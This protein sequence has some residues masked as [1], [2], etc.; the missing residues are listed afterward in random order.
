MD[1]LSAIGGLASIAQIAGGILLITKNLNDARK[2][3]KAAD[4][5]IKLL[6]AELLS[7]KAAVSQIEDWARYNSEE[8][9]MPLELVDAFKISFEACHLAMEILAD[10]VA[11]LVSNNPFVVKAGVAWNEATMKD[12]ADRLRSQVS[13]LQLLIQAVHCHNPRQQRDLLETERSRSIIQQVVDDTSTIRAGQG[14]SVVGSDPPTIASNRNSTIGSTIFDMDPELVNT[15]PYRR[16]RKHQQSNSFDIQAENPFR[17]DNR[18]ASI[19]IPS[20]PSRAP[21]TTPTI[22]TT[23]SEESKVD[24][25]YQ[26]FYD[27]DADIVNPERYRET[28]SKTKAQRESNNPIARSVSDPLV[29]PFDEPKEHH[30]E[31]QLTPMERFRFK[32]PPSTFDPIESHHGLRPMRHVSLPEPAVY[33]SPSKSPT[34]T[35]KR[36]PWGTLRRLTSRATL[37]PSSP[38]PLSPGLSSSSG[39]RLPIPR[40]VK[41]RSEANI[42]QSIDFTSQDGLTAPPIVRAAQS[43]SRVEINRLLEQSVDINARHAQ[44]GKTALAVASHCGNDDVVAVLLHHRAQVDTQDVLGMTPLHLSASRGH[45]KVME[46]LLRDYADVDTCTLDGRTPL[47]LACDG[48]HLTCVELLL[49]YR[50]KVNARDEKMVTALMAA[51]TIGDVQIIELLIQNGADKEAKD[52]SLR[53][54][55]HYASEND[56]DGVVEKLL[57]FKTDIEST[58]SQGKTPLCCACASG[59]HQ[60]AA[61]LISRKANTRHQADNNFTPLHF[62]CLYDRADTAE[63]LLQQKRVAVDARNNEGQTPLHL[64]AMNKSFSAAELLLRRGAAVEAVCHRTL[65][66]IHHACDKSD[67]NMLGLLLGNGAS[68]EAATHEGYRP[69]H[70]AAGRPGSETVISTLLRKGAQVD[71][72]NNAGDRALCI[73]AARGQMQAVKVLLQ[74]R[75]AVSLRLPKSPSLQ[76]SPLCKAARSGFGDVVS[77]LLRQ[78][79]SVDQS[80]ESNWPPLRY[81]AYYGHPHVVEVLLM[82]GASLRKNTGLLESSGEYVGGTAQFGFADG[83]SAARKAEVMQWLES[84]AQRKTTQPRRLDEFDPYLTIPTTN[85]GPVREI[86][87]VD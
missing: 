83:V 10:Q 39:L 51:A 78:G 25:G 3:Y 18:S 21:P 2:R 74:H 63:L 61:L 22:V 45:Y 42:H 54:A 16:A 34:E 41:R 37:S 79:A 35:P 65:R 64:A 55:M 77:E 29:R 70:F 27:Q 24:S 11:K 85:G 17:K 67:H 76:D 30:S 84:A 23:S 32:P 8:C 40:T 58:G 36:S 14:R 62:A 66:P 5:T 80:D 87:E 60:T 71:A 38:S 82:A 49:E 59:S 13:A 6:I 50:A 43:G 4:T 44:S 19:P 47:R 69:I 20:M 28:I 31:D 12:H 1:P 57:D 86:Y 56:Y 81:A 33:R 72:R 46:Y 9:A 75:S 68:V 53:S 73:A 26:A 52:A 7:I 15:S 48:G